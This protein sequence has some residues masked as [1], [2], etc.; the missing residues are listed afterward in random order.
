MTGTD[1]FKIVKEGD[2]ITRV[3][4]A[5]KNITLVGTAHVSPESVAEVERVI[6]EE[7]PDRVC[8][9]IDAGRYTSMT[10]E[11]SWKNMNIFKVIREKKGF[12]LLANLILSS[13]QRRIGAGL[14]TKSGEDMMASIKTAE[15]LNI[16]FSLSDRDIQTT[17]KRAWAKSSFW[18]KNKLLAVLISSAFSREEVSEEEMEDLKSRSSLDNM[19]VE[20]GRELPTVKEVLIDERDQYL[21]TSVFNE[22]EENIVAVVGA[23]H[24]PG[25]LIWFKELYNKE[26]EADLSE[27]SVIPPSPLWVKS[28]PWVLPLLIIGLI[29]CGFVFLGKD[30]GTDM[31]VKWVLFNGTLSA[32]GSLIALA[33]PVTVILAFA[34]APITSLNPLMGVGLVTGLSEAFFR[35]PK[36]VDFEHVNDD[37]QSFKGWYRNRIT[38]ILLVLLLSSVGS[39]AGTWIAGFSFFKDLFATFIGLF[40]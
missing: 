30:F 26:K 3:S 5:K 23:G 22:E 29:T 17:L 39:V 28:L 40:S 33:H 31:I 36:V 1:D 34:A 18:N 6:T 13:F 19:M 8:V 24:V 15:K 27:I 37:I 20:L 11:K 25:M 38:H 14:G 10:E 32:V 21:A 12:L 2:T 35:K 9:E 16:P 4:W 7:K